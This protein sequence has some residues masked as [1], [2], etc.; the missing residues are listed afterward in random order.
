[1]KF[2][3]I[4]CAILF[5]GDLVGATVNTKLLTLIGYKAAIIEYPIDQS[6]LQKRLGLP[7][8]PIIGLVISGFNGSRFESYA[9]VPIE[10]SDDSNM[11]SLRIFFSDDVT[12]STDRLQRICRIDLICTI[13]AGLALALDPY[14]QPILVASKI[15]ELL[16]RDKVP[17]ESI[18]DAAIILRY[19]D[20]AVS[21]LV[22]GMGVN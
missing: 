3:I 6:D 17:I 20:L 13:K 7:F 10:V 21:N 16:K 11:Y 1:M 18:D 9:I 4:L 8:S 12:H 14:Q 15:R 5:G 22:R 19:R 2:F